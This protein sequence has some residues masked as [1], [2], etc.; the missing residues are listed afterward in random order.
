MKDL[1]TLGWDIFTA[2]YRQKTALATEKSI[3]TPRNF[4]QDCLAELVVTE[5]SARAQTRLLLTSWSKLFVHSSEIMLPMMQLAETF[6]SENIVSIESIKF[7]S[8]VQS[9]LEL[10]A[11]VIQSEAESTHKSGAKVVMQCTTSSGKRIEIVAR[12]L[13]KPITGGTWIGHQELLSTSLE[14]QIYPDIKFSISRNAT[15]PIRIVPGL[16]ATLKSNNQLHTLP[17]PTTTVLCFDIGLNIIGHML[18]ESAESLVL[19]CRQLALPATQWTGIDQITCHALQTQRTSR[20]LQKTLF[21]ITILDPN[22]NRIGGGIVSIGTLMT[23]RANL[24][25]AARLYRGRWTK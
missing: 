22:Y 11:K 14:G 7:I 18:P 21:G 6:S 15:H 25:F 8:P 16:R 19:G 12:P 2:K 17:K 4:Q 1:F 20:D 10:E 24:K 9:E 13:K 23:A 5:Q 3:D